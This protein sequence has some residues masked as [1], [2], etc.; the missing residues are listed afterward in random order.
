MRLTDENYAEDLLNLHEGKEHDYVEVIRCKDCANYGTD[1]I[2]GW[3]DEHNIPTTEDQYC[4]WAE[5]REHGGN[6]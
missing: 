5:R 4:S 2:G 1:S 6:D 3:C